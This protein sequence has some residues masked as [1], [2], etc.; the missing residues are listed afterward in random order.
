MAIG[1]TSSAI[2]IQPTAG[3]SATTSRPPAL[4]TVHPAALFSILDHFLRRADSQ[5]RVIGTLL[6]T[7]TER[8]VEIRTAFPVLHGESDEQV[9]VDMD[10]HTQMF[11]MHQKVAPKEV[12]VGWYSTGSNL[13][14]FSALI[15][16][17]YTQQTAPHS[18]VH[19]TMTTGVQDDTPGVKTYIASPVG[20]FPKPENS[21]FVPVPC[22][23]RYH[24]TERAGLDLL[25]TAA[26]AP[27][28][29]TQP[30]ADLALLERTLRDVATMVDRVLE[31]VR[32]VLAGEREGNVA[33]GRYLMDTL[34]T[35]S[36]DA[37]LDKGRLESLF[38][39]QL[40]DTLMLSYL[41]NLVRSQV[42]VSS[43]LVLLT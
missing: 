28:H 3:A 34:G 38:N 41:G 15:H 26:R 37:G 13:N 32:A 25:A 39:A 17:F 36:P 1:T 43:R 14:T 12:I 2:H 23:L 31:Y 9:A 19:L 8:E 24:D 16:N 21:L 30:I 18:A 11:E 40:Q 35:V 27:N 6:G 20:V 42:E 33:V 29:S 7:R 4:V 10:Y 22:E 5:E